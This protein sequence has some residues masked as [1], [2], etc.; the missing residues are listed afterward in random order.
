[1]IDTKVR[2]VNRYGEDVTPNGK[3]I[4]EI[5]VKGNGVTT[6]EEVVNQNLIDGWLHTGD[7]GT[8]DEQ[9]R[10]DVVDRNKETIQDGENISPL[11]IESIFY[12]HPAVKDVALIILP[13][14]ELGETS[15]AFVVRSED[16]DITEQ[17]LIDFAKRKLKPSDCPTEIKFM[18]EL[19]KTASGKILKVQ[20]RELI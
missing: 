10:I 4:G 13:H 12:Q 16:S 1:M 17:E 9:G 20:L 3:E 8:I 19:P 15:H 7:M 11:E 6:N 14:V 18:D 5:I 2:V